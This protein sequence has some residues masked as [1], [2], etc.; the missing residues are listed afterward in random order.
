MER[1]EGYFPD[2]VLTGHDGRKV[3]FYEDLLRDKVVLINFMY[4]NCD[5]I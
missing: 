3:R 4:V 2:Y 5:G 1:M